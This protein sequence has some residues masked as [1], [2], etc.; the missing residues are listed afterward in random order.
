MLRG[1]GRKT[2]RML[3]EAGAV[4][5]R[6][7]RVREGSA[8]THKGRWEPRAVQKAQCRKARRHVARAIARTGV[9]P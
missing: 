4:K 6:L 3:G 7:P 1:A 5:S 2:S 9:E 8:G